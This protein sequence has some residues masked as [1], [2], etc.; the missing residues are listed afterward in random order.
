VPAFFRQTGCAG[1]RERLASLSEEDLARQLRLLAFALP[2]GHGRASTAEIESDPLLR[3]AEAIAAQIGEVEARAAPAPRDPREVLEGSYL[4]EGRL[5]TAVF[6][7]ALHGRTGDPGHADS[8]RRWAGPVVEAVAAVEALGAGAPSFPLGACNGSGG[9]VYSLVLLADLLGEPAWERAAA[10]AARWITPEAIAADE[11]L[12]VEGG[13]AGAILALLSLAARTGSAD[14]RERAAACGEHLL[15]RA[16]PAPG[17]GRAW[18]GADGLMRPG[19]AHGASG[20]ALSL[21]RLAGATGQDRFYDAVRAAAEYERT[22]YDPSLR[23]WPVV[24]D[25]GSA[26]GSR[27]VAMG[28]WCHGAAGI[29]LARAG[30]TDH[31]REPWVQKDLV[32]ALDATLAAGLGGVDHLCCGNMGRLEAML[33]GATLAGDRQLRRVVGLRAVL[34]LRRA[35]ENGR[36]TLGE[37]T[38]EGTSLSVGFFRGLAG[39]GYGLLRLSAPERTASVLLFDQAGSNA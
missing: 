3:M 16:A 5:G 21:A 20:I 35:L 32:L 38:G 6:F 31:V 12:D 8:A 18:T 29:A 39:I 1:L 34:V 11:K 30:F 36:F 37:G 19:F 24:V 28:A 26:A 25:D 33:I 4:Y 14:A 2:S 7:A 13:A 15:A 10:Q 27:R 22:Q 17:G 9:I 23:D